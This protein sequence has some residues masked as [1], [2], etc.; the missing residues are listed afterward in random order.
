MQVVNLKKQELRI[1]IA[2]I[3]ALLMKVDL[4]LFLEVF[5]KMIMGITTTLESTAIGGVLPTLVEATPQHGLWI[6]L[7][8]TC[9]ATPQLIELVIPFA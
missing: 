7:T 2:Q 3:Q 8:V 1:G 6:T 4:R 9:I 5:V